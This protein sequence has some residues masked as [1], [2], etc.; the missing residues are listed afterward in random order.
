MSGHT[1]NAVVIDAPMDLVWEM[2]NDVES[3]PRLFG[4]YASAEI[5]HREGPM[6]RFRLAT[7]PDAEGRVWSW[8][9][10]RTPD[11]ETR[12][13]RAHRVETGPFEY[14]NL[15]WE[16]RSL[17][18]G[19][20][21]RWTQDFRMKPDAHID[22][23]GMTEHL[24]R[25][26]KANMAR[27]K[28]T[29]ETAV[30]VSTGP[31]DIFGQRL[32]LLAG[33]LRLAWIVYAL[34]EVGV[35][36]RLA[37]GPLPV[38]Q[39]AEL[40]GT[41]AEAL[42][43][44]LRAAA[45]VGVFV[46]DTE[47]R[48]ALTPLAEG[49]LSDSPESIRM[50]VRYNGAVTVSGPYQ[51]ILHSLRTGEAA[52][53]K[54]FGMP[55]WDYLDADRTAGDFFDETMTRMSARL[56]PAHLADIRPERFG[57][58]VDV[59]G[60]HGAFLAEILRRAPGASGTLFERPKVI[61]G[62]TP[63]LERMD[64]LPRVTMA[65]GDFFT[66]ALPADADAYVLRAVLHNWADEDAL[67]ILRRV[68][69]AMTREDQR[70]FVIEQVVGPPNEWDHAKFLDVDMLVV[71]GGVERTEPQWRELFG[72]AGF[73]LLTRPSTGRW[74]VLECRPSESGGRKK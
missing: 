72:S 68:R 34:S 33:G 21:M 16:Y 67:A 40:T 25:V 49:L 7:H 26:T 36:D 1:D 29:V 27:I 57:R 20:E 32:L 2:T 35:A 58:F 4:E 63:V 19:V 44:L 8:V 64:V 47:G 54:V 56:V 69:D 66:D 65:A 22:D 5:L 55:L 13:V 28:N 53:Q 10:E 71:F 15:R 11:P 43:R 31:G 17:D 38:E 73:D 50:L 18:S 14:M 48:F 39:L 60:G 9:S 59:G 52:C 41:H 12:T 46:E 37:E 24:N 30:R 6:V 61:A 3:W 62:A 74:T 45:A 51:E 70:L 42:R 23:A